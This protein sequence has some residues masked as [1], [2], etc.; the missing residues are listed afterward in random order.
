[1]TEIY[2]FR[3]TYEGLEKKIWREVQASS[4]YRLDQL[5]YVVLAAFDTMAYHLFSM[6][7]KGK[8][9][10][11]PGEDI[12]EDEFLD[13][14]GARLRYLEMSVGDKMK[15]TYDF[16]TEQIFHLTLKAV[17][18]MPK[19]QSSSYPRIL[20]GAGKGIIDDMAVW[21]TEELI[22]QIDRNDRTDEPIYYWDELWDY[23]DFNL[24]NANARLKGQIRKIE[25]GYAPFW[26]GYDDEDE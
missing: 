7:Y 23:R 10:E 24:E 13:M 26:T 9:Y 5:G 1:M 22:E 17:A 15:M 12:E 14:G 6:E 16:G 18:P 19:G 2:T 25:R 8:V 4:N 11:L 20:N 21:E 3:I